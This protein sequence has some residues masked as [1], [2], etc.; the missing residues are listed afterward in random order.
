MK[1]QMKHA[2]QRAC[3]PHSLAKKGIVFATSL[4]TL[5]HPSYGQHNSIVPKPSY[6]RTEEEYS[7]DPALRKLQIDLAFAEMPTLNSCTGVNKELEDILGQPDCPDKSSDTSATPKMETSQTSFNYC[8]E[9]RVSRARGLFEQAKNAVRELNLAKPIFDEARSDYQADLER[10]AT[11]ALSRK[12]D[13]DDLERRRNMVKSLAISSATML[14]TAGA[15]TVIAGKNL[16]NVGVTI[17]RSEGDSW[18]GENSF[19]KQLQRAVDGAAEDVS[20]KIEQSNE[21]DKN[22]LIESKVFT[23]TARSEIIARARRQMLAINDGGSGELLKET[24]QNID[25]NYESLFGSGLTAMSIKANEGRSK[26]E[27]GIFQEL[28]EHIQSKRTALKASQTDARKKIMDLRTPMEKE[29]STYWGGKKTDCLTSVANLYTEIEPYSDIE[30]VYAE[31]VL[32]HRC[33]TNLPYY[34]PPRW[35]FD[36]RSQDALRPFEKLVTETLL[37]KRKQALS[38]A[39][40]RL[41]VANAKYKSAAVLAHDIDEL[42]QFMAKNKK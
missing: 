24:I 10:E 34:I 22:N 41:A 2:S 19:A 14:F 35:Y 28:E 26:P 17:I 3:F 36:S 30:D 1:H 21:R 38:I 27:I 20:G 12:K 7:K 42:C 11:L 18:E 5:I 6:L 13:Q 15:G 29:C 16:L 9:K 23:R 39:G 8:P 33:P 4:L 32:P 31:A 25:S 37:E 40:T